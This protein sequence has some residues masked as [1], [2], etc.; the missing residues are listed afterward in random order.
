M[1]VFRPYSEPARSLYDALSSCITARSELRASGRE[2]AQFLT[3][4]EAAREYAIEHG[5]HVP[6][7]EQVEA[8]ERLARGHADYAAKWAYGV[9]E[10]MMRHRD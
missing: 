5:L 3:M 6:C 1:D 4:T 8:A 9:A 7:P 2:R 10:A